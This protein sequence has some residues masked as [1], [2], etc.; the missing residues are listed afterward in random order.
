TASAGGMGMPAGGQA[1][2]PMAAY[3][4][5]IRQWQGAIERLTQGVGAPWAKPSEDDADGD[6]IEEPAQR[7]TRKGSAK[8]PGRR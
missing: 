4:A 6:E 2:G 7:P 1:G 5:G 3:E 8:R